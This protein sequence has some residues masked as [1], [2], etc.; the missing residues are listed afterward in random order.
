SVFTFPLIRGNATTALKEPYSVVLTE[1]TAKKLF[2]DGDAYGKQI[3][4]DSVYYSVTGVMKDVPK[5]SHIQFEV[6]VSLATLEVQD[7]S[8]ADGDF[9]SWQSIYSN[10]VYFTLPQNGRI[11]TLQSKLDLLC[12]RENQALT[13]RKITLTTQALKDFVEGKHLAN[14]IGL[15]IESVV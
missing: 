15:S 11:Q 9:A 12:A 8:K 2:G 10:Y 4:F 6:L 14:Q 7:Q 1:R 3:V 13:N 5:F